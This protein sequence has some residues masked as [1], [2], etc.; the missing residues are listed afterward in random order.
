MLFEQMHPAWQELLVPHQDLLSE[1]E[2]KL[3]SVGD[4]VPRPE[5]V[6]RAFKTDPMSQK[7]LILGQDPYPTPEHA[8][9]LA[10]A[11]PA[12]T[13]PLPPTLLNILKELRSDLGNS[14]VKTGDISVWA[15]RGVMLL[16][17][18]LTTNAGVSASHLD[19]GWAEFTAAAVKVLQSIRGG[20][21][22]AILWG[23]KAQELAPILSEA[24][25]IAS[26]HPSPLSSYRGFFGSKP[27][28][29]TN[30]LLTTLGQPQ[31]DWSC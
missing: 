23:R 11:V 9:G 22:V 4:L 20:E 2:G 16:N 3:G 24:K 26:A 8:T 17:R 5:N 18:H 31:I 21:L 15:E 12:G 19:L 30:Q 14:A 13:N 6:L 28:T 7:V 27:F 10:F 1:I 25:V 29:K